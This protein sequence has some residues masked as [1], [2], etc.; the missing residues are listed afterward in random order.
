M[1]G[2]RLEVLPPLPPGVYFRRPALARPPFPLGQPE[3]TLYSRARQGIY[4]A[5]REVGLGPGD[6][7]LLPA[8][9]HGSEVEALIR[10]GL[11]CRFY[12]GTERLEPDQGELESLLGPRVR[13]LYLTHYLGFPQDAARWR[14]WCN[15]H[16]L[17][18]LEDAAQAWLAALDDGRPAGSLGDV[19]VFCLYKTTGVP[20]GA[21]LRLADQMRRPSAPKAGGLGFRESARGHVRWLLGR[22]AALSR[23]RHR[24]T[25][26]DD[27]GRDFALGDADRGPLEL[28]VRVLLRLAGDDPASARR[29]NYRRLLAVLRE[30]VPAPFDELPAAASPFCFPVETERKAEVL[31]RLEREGIAALDFWSV[32]HPSLPVEGFPQAARRRSRTVGLPVHQ[33]LQAR[34]VVR[35][36]AAAEAA[37]SGRPGGPSR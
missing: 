1:S 15:G 3:V 27:A 12:E 32:P 25:V 31:T 36:A 28:T 13:I 26:L 18:L 20:D 24:R 37:L 8:Y 21:A 7:V 35:I 2:P 30:H 29:D 16:G 34:D 4:A 11:A 19:A 14:A 17:L 5:A 10:A 22:S 33:E 6:Q 9:H 23:L